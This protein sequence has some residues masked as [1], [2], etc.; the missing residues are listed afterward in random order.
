MKKFTEQKRILIHDILSIY[1]EIGVIKDIDFFHL[2]E[3]K[4]IAENSN[5]NTLRQDL[6]TVGDIRDQLRN[7]ML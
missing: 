4:V 6:R 3:Y 2:T 1:Y 5:I 7:E